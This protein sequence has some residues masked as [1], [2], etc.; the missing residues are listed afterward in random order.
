MG[1]G[2]KRATAHARATRVTPG[3][4]KWLKEYKC[5]CLHVTATRKEALGYCAKHGED[6]RHIYKLDEAVAI[7][8]S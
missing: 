2:L 5:G 1:N 4:G 6:R 7:G 3:V 8:P